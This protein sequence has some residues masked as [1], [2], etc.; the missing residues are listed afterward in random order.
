MSGGTLDG[1][2]V[3]V[4]SGDL[5]F[6]LREQPDGSLYYENLPDDR[7]QLRQRSACPGRS[8]RRA[9]RWAR[10]TSSPQKVKAA[11]IT[12]VNGDVVVDDRLFTPIQ[13]PDGLVSPIWVNENLIDIEV[14]PGSAAGQPTTIDWRPQDRFVHRRDPGHHRRRQRDHRARGHRA[15]ARPPRRDGHD[16][17]RQH[18]HAGGAGDHRSV[19]VRP[20]GVHRGAAA[21]GRDGD[22]RPDRPEP[23]LA[24][25]GQGQLPGRRQARRARVGATSPRTSS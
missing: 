7:P 22:R 15:D 3:L 13:W 18:A 24:A 11:G 16:R 25:A 23:G 19:G 14:S 4:G 2:L 12:R 21:G 20:D 8:S 5:S 10:S 6:G 17:R 9:T 1:N